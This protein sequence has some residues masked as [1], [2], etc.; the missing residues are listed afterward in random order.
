[1]EVSRE[2]ATNTS[3][4]NFDDEVGDLETVANG[5]SSSGHVAW[6]PVDDSTSHVEPHLSESLLHHASQPSHF[7]QTLTNPDH[8]PQDTV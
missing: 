3:I 4:A 8:N 2:K 5:S 1:M 7:S 6:E